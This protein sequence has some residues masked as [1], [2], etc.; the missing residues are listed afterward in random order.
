MSLVVRSEV[1]EYGSLPLAPWLGHLDSL[2][3]IKSLAEQLHQLASHDQQ[4]YSKLF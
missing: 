1:I 4:G 2:H 3:A